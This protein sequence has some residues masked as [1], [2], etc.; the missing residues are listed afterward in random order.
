MNQRAAER[1]YG[2]PES[3]M[4]P[5]QGWTLAALRKTWNR[6]KLE[7]AP[8]WSENSKEAYNTGL[9]AL[10]RALDAWRKSRKGERRGPNIG[11]PRFKA[12]HRAAKSIRFTTGAIRVER[13]RCHVTLPRLGSI[14]THESTR[15]LARRVEAGTARILSATVRFDGGRWH[16]SFQTIV[17]GKQRPAHVARSQHPIV[18]VDAGVKDLLVVAA[19][20]GTEVDRIQAPKP[21]AAA[22]DKLWRLQ[23]RAARRQGP[24]DPETK[25]RRDPSNR[26][27]ATTVQVGK[28]HGRVSSLR[29]HELHRATSRLAREHDVLV[30]EDLSVAA[31]S[32]HGGRRKRGLNRA[33]ADASLAQVRRMLG[34]KALWYGAELVVADRWFASTQLCSG[35]GAKTKL[36][37]SERIYHCGACG[38]V[39]DRDF[40]AAVNLARLGEPTPVGGASGTGT[41]TSPAASHRVG[42]GRGVDQKTSLTGTVRLAGGVET[43]TPH[44]EALADQTG[45]AASQGGAA[46]SELYKY[47]QVG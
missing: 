4:T 32:R 13:D 14:H 24:W 36:P 35:C 43:S 34:Y 40:N 30:V 31:M 42:Q 33:L 19:P 16:C 25:T 15:K 18:G 12:K 6:R 2:I 28:T 39:A 9:D 11:F 21:L 1:S 17:A 10:A 20:D 8:W 23:R 7:H 27:R 3:G 45:T 26:W 44:S 41:G 47:A 37:L 22:Q 5:P 29:R 38:L 46:R